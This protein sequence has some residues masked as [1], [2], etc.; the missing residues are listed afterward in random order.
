MS[1]VVK[2]AKIRTFTRVDDDKWT[3][4]EA[5]LNDPLQYRRLLRTQIEELLALYQHYPLP[6]LESVRQILS[7][8]QQAYGDVDPFNHSLLAALDDEEAA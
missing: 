6:E 2:L 4:T 8:L 7:Q 3:V 5:I 1:N